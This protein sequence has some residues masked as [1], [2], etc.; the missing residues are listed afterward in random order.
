LD[1]D[2]PRFIALPVFFGPPVPAWR[3]AAVARQ[4]QRSRAAR[5]YRPVQAKRSLSTRTI[6]TVCSIEL[7]A[8]P[9]HNNPEPTMTS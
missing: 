8:R 3:L 2:E 7:P 6:T 4:V 5:P 9:T 1:Y